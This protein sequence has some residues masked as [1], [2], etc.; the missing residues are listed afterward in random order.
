MIDHFSILIDELFKIEFA[1]GNSSPKY[2]DGLAINI[3]VAEFKNGLLT[4]KIKRINLLEG[5]VKEST[6]I[7]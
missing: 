5:T 2:I 7:I 4:G 6:K 3:Y 1:Y